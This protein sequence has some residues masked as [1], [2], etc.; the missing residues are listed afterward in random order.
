MTTVNDIFDKFKMIHPNNG[1]PFIPIPANVTRWLWHINNAPSMPLCERFNVLDLQPPH[2][3]ALLIAEK[4]RFKSFDEMP[5][6]MQT[7]YMTIS[8]LFPGVTMFACGS[9]TNGQWIDPDEIGGYHSHSFSVRFMRM[10]LRKQPKTVSDYDF[11]FEHLPNGVTFEDVKKKLPEWADYTPNVPP[12]EK[13]LLPMGWDFSKLPD[14]QHQIVAE[15]FFAHRWRALIEIHNKFML[16]P[17]RICCDTTIVI[18]WFR[19][20]IVEQKIINYEPNDE[21]KKTGQ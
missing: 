18:R 13:I 15:H 3:D 5:E 12:G 9:R 14:D 21:S 10:Q 19:W 8:A 17:N 6:Y 1:E 11:T 7:K 2:P 4:R 20:A 16:S